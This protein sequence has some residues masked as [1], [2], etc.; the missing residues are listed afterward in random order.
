MKALQDD[1]L[2]G[3]LYRT[4]LLVRRF[5]ERVAEIYPSDRIKSPMHLSIGQESVAVGVCDALAATDWVSGTYRGH[6]AY[7]ARGGDP[8]R[9]MAE[10]F[11]KETGGARGR[12]GSMHLIDTANHVMGMS[13]VVGTTVPIAVGHALT[14][15]RKRTGQAV[16]A[17][18]G[19]GATEEGSFYESLNFAALHK[20]PVL[21]VCEN[22]FLAIHEPI[23]KRWATDRLAE[24]VGTFGIPV[25]QVTR[26]DVLDIRDA[27]V[28][29]MAG[30][31]DGSGPGFME[32]H[33]WRWGEHVGPGDDHDAGFRSRA[34]LDAW[35]AKD[36]LRLLATRLPDA[37]RGSM[38]REVAAVIDDAIAFAEASPFPAPSTLHDH[39]FA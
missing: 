12:G 10:L 38:E 31:R 29:L 37:I 9:M 21:F 17:F 15:K 4:L 6:A 19:D 5:E 22:N 1:E 33:T 24:R 3:R 23:S 7:L 27:A 11:G 18:F 16:A 36:S 14:F 35:K 8:R 13:A 25:R 32:C 39:V 28:A 26:G 34:D 30:I 20:L 2:L